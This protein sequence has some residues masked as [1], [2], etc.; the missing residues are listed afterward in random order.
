MLSKLELGQR[1]SLVHA[2]SVHCIRWATNSTLRRVTA[3]AA[4]AILGGSCGAVVGADRSPAG[5]TAEASIGVDALTPELEGRPRRIEARIQYMAEVARSAAVVH[6]AA[7]QAGVP[8]RLLADATEVS[9]DD[10]NTIRVAT[11]A[12]TSEAAVARAT[13]VVIQ[14]VQAATVG[15]RSATSRVALIGDFEAGVGQWT[16]ISSPASPFPTTEIRP[17][18][19]RDAHRGQGY[20]EVDCRK[21]S[22]CGMRSDFSAFY[23]PGETYALSLWVRSARSDVRATLLAGPS[24]GGV[25]SNSEV[26]SR[27]WRRLQVRWTPQTPSSIATLAIETQSRAR[28]VQFDV[29]AITVVGGAAVPRPALPNG[30]DVAAESTAS[31]LGRYAVVQLGRPTGRS[32]EPPVRMV[33]A[34]LLVGAL[35]AYSALL[36]AAAARRRHDPETSSS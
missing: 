33:A 1:A 8:A 23:R 9:V 4:C 6:A 30:L 20:A 14:T 31:E 17:V 22:E 26:V 32:G 18:R 25:E 21:P 7:G 15:L 36:A 12:A 11:R 28:R 29:D 13:S 3:V 24:G 2:A 10:A 5:D 19:R 16:P 35:T 27:S 34:G